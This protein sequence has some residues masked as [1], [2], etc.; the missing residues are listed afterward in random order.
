MAKT[1]SSKRFF[2]PAAASLIP[3]D[4][5]AWFESADR[6]KEDCTLVVTLQTAGEARQQKM[7]ARRQLEELIVNEDTD[8]STAWV[9]FGYIFGFMTRT[10]LW[11]N[12]EIYV[13]AG[14]ALFLYRW[15]VLDDDT[16]RMQRYYLRHL[17]KRFGK[18]FLAEVT[19]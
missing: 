1:L 7:T 15:L 4:V 13:T 11:K 2:I 5:E 12:E 16:H 9:R 8:T 3:P 10:Y 6:G 18:E 19:A 14:E 17:R